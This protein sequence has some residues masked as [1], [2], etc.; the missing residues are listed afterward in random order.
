M[1]ENN[2]WSLNA[3]RWVGVQVNVHVMLFLFVAF[4]FSIQWQ[5]ADSFRPD[6][7]GTALVTALVLL[8]SVIAHEIGHLFALANLGGTTHR[9]VLTPWGS[10]SE[11]EMPQSP[12]SQ[13]IV[14]V[15]GPFVNLGIFLFTASL[16]MQTN[17]SQMSEL[18][19][20]LSPQKF[21]A[22]AGAVSLFKIAAWINFYL[23]MIN[24]IPCFPFDG[25]QIVR[26]SLNL[27]HLNASKIRTECAIMVLG[28]GVGMATFGL[29]LF[30]LDYDR[31]PIQPIWFY[32]MAAGIGLYFAARYSFEIETKKTFDEY[33]NQTW[34]FNH[35]AADAAFY[36]VSEDYQ[37]HLGDP[38]DED[39][40]SQSQWMTE[41]QEARQRELQEREY[42][43]DRK[44]DEILQ[45]IH[46]GGQGIQGLSEDERAILNR[47]S[48]RLRRRRSTEQEIFGDR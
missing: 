17:I 38:S 43:E 35:L 46:I 2:N 16:L 36:G 39:M 21:D 10:N 11:I 29:S 3:G 6:Q 1:N 8:L 44:A 7:M 27:M 26:S 23:L 4:I 15:A 30:L 22:S 19:Q 37:L 28:N 13:L 45:K 33:G 32:V 20:P 41:K 24:L 31:G 14:S 40:I 42:L 9:I 34:N 25:A 12:W 47:V 48:D 5:F 18:I